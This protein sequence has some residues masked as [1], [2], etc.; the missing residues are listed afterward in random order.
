MALPFNRGGFI[1]VI[2]SW[3]RRLHYY[4]GLY[5]VLFLWLFSFTGL[6]LNHPRWTLSRIPNNPN[7]VYERTIAPPAGETDLARA[8]DVIRQLGLRGEIDWPQASAAPGTLE[9]NLAYPKQASQVRVDLA[10]NRATVRQVQRSFWSVLRISHTFSG[11]RYNAPGTSR[12]WILTSMWVVAMDALAAGLLAMVFGSY[13]MW[14]R[15]KA[16]RG[17]G[18]VVLA[19]GFLSCGLFVVGLGWRG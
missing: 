16:K 1:G 19:A 14:Y 13:Y 10:L 9:L 7:P 6:L 2:E 5:V 11:S 18:W 8:N 17:L 12:D 4:V 3:N 15:L